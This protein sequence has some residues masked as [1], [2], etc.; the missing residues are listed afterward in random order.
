MHRMAGQQDLNRAATA[1]AKSTR[2]WL[3]RLK[4]THNSFNYAN[5]WQKNS[6]KSREADSPNIYLT[7]ERVMIIKYLENALLAG[8]SKQ[9]WNSDVCETQTIKN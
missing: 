5:S 2:T 8:Q 3:K 1:A 6:H 4:L 7:F 9:I